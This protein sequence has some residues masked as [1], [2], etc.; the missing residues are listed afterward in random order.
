MILALRKKGRVKI[1]LLV[2]WAVFGSAFA[3]SLRPSPAYW[4]HQGALVFALFVAIL[5]GAICALLVR[6]S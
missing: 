1:F 4:W 6:T 2:F 5:G 3:V